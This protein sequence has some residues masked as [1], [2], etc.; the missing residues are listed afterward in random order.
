ML[1]VDEA[2]ALSALPA[3][4]RRNPA[5]TADVVAALRRVAAATGPLAGDRAVRLAR[6][7]RLL[8]EAST[9]LLTG[10]RES[11]PA[12]Q[13]SRRNGRTKTARNAPESADTPEASKVE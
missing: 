8:G 9:A 12:I 6:I 11:P 4:A 1:L 10:G 2:A 3:I 5:G 13:T 7:E